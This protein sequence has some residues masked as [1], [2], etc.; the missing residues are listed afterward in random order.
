[1]AKDTLTLPEGFEL[2]TEIK[3]PEGFELERLEP[4]EDFLEKF[5]LS[6]RPIEDWLP[7]E[8]AGLARSILDSFDDPDEERAKMS[9]VILLSELF[10][11]SFDTVM[12]MQPE[13]MKQTFGKELKSISDL[14]I[15]KTIKEDVIAALKE[16]PE[17][18]WIGT[19]GMGASTLAA[20]KRQSMRFAGGGIFPDEAILNQFEVITPSPEPSPTGFNFKQDRLDFIRSRRLP[21]AITAEAFGLVTRLP[22]LGAKILRS[23]QKE[24]QQEQDIAMMSNA[25]I[26]KLS[27]LVMQSGVPSVGVAAG[28]SILTGNPLI[29][30]AILGELEGGAAFQQQLETGGS[31]RKALIIGDLS[32]A[33][34]IGGE[35]LVFPKIIK[36]LTEGISLR[37][38]LTLIIENATQEG[39]TGFNQRF[40]EVFGNETTK[41]TD[42]LTAAKLAFTEGYKAIPENAFVGGATAGLADIPATGIGIMK[43][44]QLSKRQAQ[45]IIGDIVSQIETELAQPAEVPAVGVRPEAAVLEAEKPVAVAP[46][47]K[48]AAPA[49]AVKPEKAAKPLPTKEVTAEKGKEAKVE[50]EKAT[51][52]A[53]ITEGGKRTEDF[54]P[55]DIKVG[56]MSQEAIIKLKKKAGIETVHAEK[57][58][59]GVRLKVGGKQFILIDK[60]LPS[61]VKADAKRHEL[62]HAGIDEMVKQG[63]KGVEQAKELV[64]FAEQNPEIDPVLISMIGKMREI[65]YETN[66]LAVE[67]LAEGLLSMDRVGADLVNLK[68]GKGGAIQRALKERKG[69][70]APAA[71]GKVFVPEQIQKG[72]A[73]KPV[74]KKG[75]G[76]TKAELAR[77]TPEQQA[78]LRFQQTQGEKVGFKAGEKASQER[79]KTEILKLKKAQRLTEGRRKTAVE[80]IKA[81]VEKEQRGDFIKRIAEA[82]TP[83]DIEKI[84]EAIEKGITRA[85][86]KLAIGNLKKAAKAISPKRMLPEFAETA[87]KIL[88]S[89]QIG[90][91]R[92]DTVVKNAE[93]KEMAQQVLDTAREDSVAAFQA[94]QILNEL[95]EKT[96]KTFAI[97]QLSVDAI[98]QIT[99]TLIA[100]RFQNEADTIAA[101]DENATEAIRRRKEIKESIVETP[102]VPESL[103]G[104][105]LKKF[106]LFHDNMES[107][108]DAVAGARPGTYDLWVKNKRATTEFIYDVLNRGVDNQ[109]IH[110][111]KARDILRQILTD[112]NVTQEDILNWS[113]RPE[114]ISIVKEVFGIAPKPEVHTF[115]LA[116][117]KGKAAEFEFTTNELMSLFMHSRNNHNLSVLLNDGLDRTIQRN[118][119]KIRG[120]TIEVI[121]DMI[122]SLTDQQ[123][124]VARQVGSKLMDGFNKDSINEA[125]IRLE[126]FELAKVE[127][128]WPARRSIIR[129]PKGKQIAGAV[130]TVEGMGLLKERVG[131]GNPMRLSGFFETVYSTNKNVSTY[132][133]LAESLREVKSVY[134]TD[135]IEELE[136]NG[137]S[138]E[139]KLITNLIVRFEDQAALLGPLDTMIK[140]MLGGFAKAKLFLNPKIAIRQQIS[141]FLI[142]AYVDK[143]YI[144]EFKGIATDEIVDEIGKLSP[145]TKAR[146]AQLQFDR[147]IG[148]AFIENELMNYLTGTTT[149]ID[150]TALGMRFFDKN[151]IVD[152]YRAVKAEVIDK[153]P[154]ININS[155]EG[156]SLLK[157]RFEWVTRHTQPMWHP[158]DRSLI[159]SDPRPLIRALTMF[160]SQ[161][162]Q[163]VRMVNNGIADYVNSEKTTEDATRL[164]RSLGNVA[165]NM[166]AFT[167]Y[168]FAWAVL[169]HKKKRDVWDLAK[170]FFKDILS[171]PFFGKYIAK[172]FEISF[173]VLT[174]KPVFR[175]SFDEGPIESILGGILIEA[176][177]NFVRAAKHFVTKERYKSGPN[178][179]EEKWE[180]ELLVAIDALVDTVASLKGIPYYG[181]KDI[182][183][184]VKVQV[185]K[186]EKSVP[187]ITAK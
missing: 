110:N 166:A 57:V 60:S 18:L 104:K 168:N 61:N 128:Y 51:E 88:D 145:Q 106:K 26:T 96:A 64:E 34:E 75:P 159:G 6:D 86:K 124:K 27:R 53:D 32:A 4:R 139:A 135:V 122:D 11:M 45:K 144:A 56:E 125:S 127:R 90:K 58:A 22:D 177:P 130:K 187:K 85:E 71:E 133:G 108:L 182:V 132:A 129:T 147:D 92:P 148:D 30:L 29:G 154:N 123:K 3:P 126:F 175:Q 17:N 99:D 81:F 65:G 77:L 163:L 54:A 167:L 174:E 67:M 28:V 117:A 120:F 146:F 95:R 156:Q 36:G 55:S 1:M 43:G 107:A 66:E 141:S 121:D 14:V 19:V 109:V 48:I 23:K 39:A 21:G 13:L 186:D 184:S 50:L 91:L 162:E 179:G 40:L 8:Q 78:K 102:E 15:N 164:G 142:N 44:R 5:I 89:I 74:S 152:V 16:T 136:N 111:E 52:L 180:N 47:A 25:P 59:D 153:N 165:L 143:K 114:D 46:E 100:L 38:A 134:T 82:K 149:L 98:D 49:K 68:Q 12:N 137:R 80:M 79:A 35:M 160:M 185:T 116:D 170:S 171:L 93:L 7:D 157:D 2:E 72:K 113:M 150:K 105:Q 24:L 37:K 70:Q 62:R 41:G 140:R 181:A 94:Q 172:S 69:K 173:N 161:R 151:A 76:L 42:K 178:R 84:S 112:N 103:G 155:K 183:K 87:K 9:N 158:K 169:I 33:A 119:Q 115:T 176:I 20:M 31:V 10:G 73:F 138:E 101:K 97:N 131:I 63:H 83:R 118:K